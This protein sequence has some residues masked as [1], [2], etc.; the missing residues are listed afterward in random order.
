MGRKDDGFFLPNLLDDFSNF[1]DLV[2]IQT[3]SRFIQ[4]Q[5]LRIVH[6]GMSQTNPLLEAL[7]KFAYGLM[8]H[9]I[10]AAQIGQFCEFVRVSRR[11]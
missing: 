8:H 5:N 1:H 4:N 3:R 7:G 6:H 10:Q 11:L 2:G 9:L